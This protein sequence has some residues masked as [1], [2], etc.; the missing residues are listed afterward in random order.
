MVSGPEPLLVSPRW[1]IQ[2]TKKGLPDPE[3]CEQ[4]T[5][6]RPVWLLQVAENVLRV[7]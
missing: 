1:C 7:Q 4:Q 2:D 6:N 3:K 5:F